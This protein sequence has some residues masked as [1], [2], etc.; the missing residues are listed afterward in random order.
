MKREAS[1]IVI[2]EVETAIIEYRGERVA[3][4]DMIDKLHMR[5]DGT[6][7]RN[8]RDNRQR[9]VEGEDFI[10]VGSDEIRRDLPNGTFSKFTPSGFL[11]TRRGYLKLV[12]SLND[13]VAWSIFDQMIDRYFAPERPSLP[14]FADPAAAARAWA[15]EHEARVLAERTKAQIGQRREATAMATASHAVQRAAK[16]EIALD[17]SQSYAT[18]KRM[19]ALHPGQHFNWRLLKRVSS[20]VGAPSIDTF[21]QNYGSVKSYAAEAWKRAYGLDVPTHSGGRQ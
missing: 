14:N 13:D 16:L 17:R 5:P 10:E 8:F 1:S 18:I 4:F 6:A 9:F 7:G 21:D 3:T 2:G 20:E 12:K 11:V 15:D 19:E